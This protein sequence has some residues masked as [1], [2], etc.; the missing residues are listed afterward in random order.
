MNPRH[1]LIDGRAYAWRELVKMRR[2]QLQAQ[3]KRKQL[4][5]FEMKED[6]RPETHRTASGRYRQ[7]SLLA[8]LEAL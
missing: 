5:L 8:L 4:A 1:I 6:Y 3:A 2:E 7:P